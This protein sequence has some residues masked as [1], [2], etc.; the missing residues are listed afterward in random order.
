MKSILD[1]IRQTRSH[2]S[3]KNVTIPT[4]DLMKMLEGAHYSSAAANKQV[5]RYALVNDK[6]ICSR[7]F[8]DVVWASQ[9]EWKPTEDEAPGGY[10]IILTDNPPKLPMNFIYPDCGIAIQNMRLIA[11]ELGYGTNIMEPVKKDD[12]LKILNISDSYTPLFVIPVGVPTDDII[13]ID[14][15]D[16]NM[17][18]SRESEGDHHYRHFVPKLPLD[19]LIIGKNHN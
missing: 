15:V 10:I 19:E 2:R 18:Y 8:K 14:A 16:D 3:F 13:I 4:E 12:I 6:E 7:L 9:I 11:T 1:M 5:L 17:K